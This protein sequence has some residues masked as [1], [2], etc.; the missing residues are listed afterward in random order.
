MLFSSFSFREIYTY[1]YETMNLIYIIGGM[2]MLNESLE[3]FKKEEE[4]VTVVLRK[5]AAKDIESMDSDTFEA[6]QAVFGFLKASTDLIEEQTKV[7]DQI[8]EKLD[9]LLRDRA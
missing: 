7:L 3:K 5:A 2:I 9:K 6:I 4:K 1:L 8:N